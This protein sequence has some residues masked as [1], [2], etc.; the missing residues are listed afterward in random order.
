MSIRSALEI[1]KVFDKTIKEEVCICD[2]L[3]L[4]SA[5]VPFDKI[6]SNELYPV[7]PKHTHPAFIVNGKEIKRVYISK[8]LNIVYQGRAYSLKGQ[9]PCTMISFDE[10]VEACRKKGRGWGLMPASLWAAIALWCMKNNTVPSGNTKFG[11]SYD[12]QF[13]KGESADDS[14]V[15]DRVYITKTGSGPIEWNHNHRSDGIA[16]MVGNVFEWQA[17]L[18]AVGP[19]LQ[20]IPDANSMD[21]TVSMAADSNCWRGIDRNGKYTSDPENS[22]SLDFDE[23]VSS[24]IYKD[25]SELKSV[26]NTAR[27]CEFRKMKCEAEAPAILKE[28]ALYPVYGEIN[29]KRDLFYMANKLPEGI[30]FRGG[31]FD[32]DFMSGLFNTGINML[33]TDKTPYIGF[34][35]VYY[36]L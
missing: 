12:N 19:I 10:A 26:M 24:F 11:C 32:G 36:E 8:Y 17:G 27:Y 3:G 1:Q 25:R 35:S 31:Y 13:M 22:L 7:L 30:A 23:T 15:S 20:V 16:D 21:E 6:H 18:R 5:M 28:L 34:R 33:R 9:K 4:P 29:Y 2:D 14:S